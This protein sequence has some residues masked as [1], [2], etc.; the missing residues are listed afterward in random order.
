M[1]AFVL[2]RAEFEGLPTGLTLHLPSS[3][4]F[5]AAQNLLSKHAFAISRLFLFIAFVVPIYYEVLAPH[6]YLDS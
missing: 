2:A 4:D 3:I 6:P 1:A 5:R